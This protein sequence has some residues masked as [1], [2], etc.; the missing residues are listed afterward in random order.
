LQPGQAAPSLDET[1]EYSGDE[2]E[3]DTQEQSYQVI[4]KLIDVFA[5]IDI[6]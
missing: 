5:D 1:T 2:W 3:E 4:D 6:I